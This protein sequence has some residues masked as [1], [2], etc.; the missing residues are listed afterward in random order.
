[1]LPAVTFPVRPVLAIVTGTIIWWNVV[2]VRTSSSFGVHEAGQ[3]LFASYVSGIALPG[4]TSTSTLRF[5]AMSAAGTERFHEFVSTASESAIGTLACGASMVSVRDNTPL[6]YQRTR[7]LGVTAL[8][9]VA[10]T[11]TRTK[12]ALFVRS[13]TVSR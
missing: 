3:Q 12:A 11:N 8:A 1:M 2:G 9:C 7:T 10:F 4:S 13:G 5:G 6:A